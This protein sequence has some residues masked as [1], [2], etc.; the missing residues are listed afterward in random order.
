[1][2]EAYGILA[3]L[4]FLFVVFGLGGLRV[5]QQYEKGL[6]LTLGRYTSTREPGLTWIFQ[7]LQKIIKVDMRITTADIPRQEAITKDNVPVGI[8]EIGRAHV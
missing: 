5:V 2:F 7:G 4:G 8:N 6:V 1:M 3:F